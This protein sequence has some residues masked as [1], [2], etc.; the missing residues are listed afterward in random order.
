MITFADLNRALDATGIPF[1]PYEWDGGSPATPAWGAVLIGASASI[2]GDDEVCEE[3]LTG[4]ITMCTRVLDSSAFTAVTG[5]LRQLMQNDAVFC[6][7]LTGV[8]LESDKKVLFYNWRWS[9]T[10]MDRF[11]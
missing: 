8:R 11:E 9:G 1:K 7:R 6:Y 4:T 5:A 2:Y 10:A 3:Y